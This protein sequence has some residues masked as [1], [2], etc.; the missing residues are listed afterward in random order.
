MS[1]TTKLII[2]ALAYISLLGIA[3][4]THLALEANDQQPEPTEKPEQ[5]IAENYD[6]LGPFGEHRT[7]V[8][9]KDREMNVVCYSLQGVNNL[10]CVRVNQ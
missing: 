5:L 10:S 3:V 9:F 8:R 4:L 2:T 6:Q 1:T 7:L